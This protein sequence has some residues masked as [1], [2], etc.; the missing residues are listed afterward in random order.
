MTLHSKPEPKDDTRAIQ[1][2]ASH[3]GVILV[4]NTIGTGFMEERHCSLQG[5]VLSGKEPGLQLRAVPG[6]D[7]AGR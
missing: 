2:G 5:S 1:V 3:L 4:R 7:S 6:A